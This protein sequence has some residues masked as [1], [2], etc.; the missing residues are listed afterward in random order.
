MTQI[1]PLWTAGAPVGGIK[2]RQRA[3]PALTPALFILPLLTL[4]PFVTHVAD[5][6]VNVNAFSQA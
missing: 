2:V 5:F 6:P 1:V 3:S 4:L